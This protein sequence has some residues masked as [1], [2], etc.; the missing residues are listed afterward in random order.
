MVVYRDMTFCPF[1]A[2]CDFGTGCRRAMTAEVIRR[3]AK[4]NIDIAQFTDRPEC[5]KTKGEFD[6]SL[7][8]TD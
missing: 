4:A 7:H 6:D 5:Y 8:E 1:H 3:A 2:E